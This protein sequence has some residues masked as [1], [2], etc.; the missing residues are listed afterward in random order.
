MSM[1][2]MGVVKGFKYGFVLGL[3]GAIIGG[4]AVSAG[5]LSNTGLVA[6]EFGGVG[7]GLGLAEGLLE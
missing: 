2:K 5:W 7:F 6:S 3:V 1:D 4:V